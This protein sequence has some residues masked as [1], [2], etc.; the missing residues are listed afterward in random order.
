MVV[1]FTN[2]RTSQRWPCQ[3]LQQWRPVYSLGGL[4]RPPLTWIN[5]IFLFTRLISSIICNSFF[6]LSLMKCKNNFF[7]RSIIFILNAKANSDDLCISMMDYDDRRWQNKLIF[8]YLFSWFRLQ[9]A[10][11]CFVY[12]CSKVNIICWAISSIVLGICDDLCILKGDCD[13]AHC[14]YTEVYT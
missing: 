2:N 10:P 9:L 4:W 7:E 6:Y 3:I 5:L 13:N 8:Y 14:V 12:H 11:S 1:K